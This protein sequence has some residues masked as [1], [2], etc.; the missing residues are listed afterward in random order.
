MVESAKTEAV[1]C[2][3]AG[4]WAYFTTQALEAQRGDDWN[5]APYESNAGVPYDPTWH[6]NPDEVRGRGNLCKCASCQRDWNSDGTPKWQIIKIA[7]DGDFEAPDNGVLN[8]EYSVDQINS[9]AVPWLQT[10]KWR[11]DVEPF[12]IPAGTPLDDFVRL[13]RQGKGDVYF[14]FRENN[15]QEGQK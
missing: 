8:S 2:Y 9:G 3:V 4:P 6:N 11:S 5:D 10:S 15:P 13:I 7:W 14:S 1:L 12:G